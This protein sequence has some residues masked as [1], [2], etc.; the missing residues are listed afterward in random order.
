MSK[1]KAKHH[2][3]QFFS[4]A[5][6]IVV[7][8]DGEVKEQGPWD[9]IKGKTAAIAKFIPSG[10]HF[11][12]FTTAEGVANSKLTA[13]LRAKDDAEIDLARKTG[14]IALYGLHPS[15][16]PTLPS[17]HGTDPQQDTTLVSWVG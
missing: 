6:H 8:G 9:K 11:E 7:L 13:Q 15:Q 16:P 3:A 17:W 5:D 1:A 14:D 12:G 2:I 10:D 4:D